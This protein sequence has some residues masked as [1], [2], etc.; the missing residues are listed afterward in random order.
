MFEKD[1]KFSLLLD[2]YGKLLSDRKREAAEMYFNEDLSLSEVAEQLGISR[3]G[4]RELIIKAEDELLFYEER[5]EL[6][7][8]R[9]DTAKKVNTIERMMQSLSLPDDFVS[10]LSG[11]CEQLKK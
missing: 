11:L 10:E 8:L 4:V 5:L 1:L 9:A 7:A 2:F 6:V 3:Q